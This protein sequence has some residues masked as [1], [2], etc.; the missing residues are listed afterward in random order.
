MINHWKEIC[1]QIETTDT[2]L[3]ELIVNSSLSALQLKKL[4]KFIAEWN[5]AKKM[6]TSFNQF[7]APTEPISVKSPFSGED[8]P[9]VW[10]TWKDYLL[11]QHQRM[12]KSRMEQASLDYLAELSESNP[13]LA[14]SYLR[15]AMANGYKSFFRVETKD[16]TNPAKSDRYGSDF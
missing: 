8:F 14:I 6:V 2:R 3:S 15:Y 9:A 13:Q 10:G 4:Q 12:M 7:M 11:E 1:Q 16:K 5:K